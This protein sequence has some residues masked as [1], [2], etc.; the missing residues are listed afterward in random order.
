MNLINELTKLITGLKELLKNVD[1]IEFHNIRYRQEI[2]YFLTSKPEFKD[3][4]SDATKEEAG[5]NI[6]DKE[7]V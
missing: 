1:D 2:K 4:F 7:I 6:S 3:W 5:I